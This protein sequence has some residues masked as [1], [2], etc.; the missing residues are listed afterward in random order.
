M[1]APSQRQGSRRTIQ[2]TPYSPAEGLWGDG[3]AGWTGQPEVSTT[4]DSYLAI[5]RPALAEMTAD[6]RPWTV[7]MISALSIPWR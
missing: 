1:P 7:S 2:E 5:W 4:A 3:S 6:G